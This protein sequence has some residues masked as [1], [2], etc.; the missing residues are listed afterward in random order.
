[1]IKIEAV[2]RNSKLHAVQDALL[3][4]GIST[5]SSYEI[6]LAGLHKGHVTAGG[7]P[8]TF[9]ASG[10]IPKTNIVIICPDKDAE[11]IVDTISKAAKTGQ[12]GDGLI[13][14]YSIDKLVK[15]RTGQ[16]GEAAIL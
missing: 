6:K 14:L 3:D 2:V 1:M 9:K 4:I 5:F 16:T 15:I 11:K 10:L 13:S 7:R 12:K 8:G